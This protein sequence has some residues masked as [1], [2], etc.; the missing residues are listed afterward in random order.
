MSTLLVA[1]CEVFLGSR[2]SVMEGINWCQGTGS[3]Q[4]A[5]EL[6][7]KLMSPWNPVKQC[8]QL[9]ASPAAMAPT[10]DQAVEGG[11]CWA[12]S[13]RA[14]GSPSATRPAGA[15]ALVATGLK[16]AVFPSHPWQILHG[17]QARVPHGCWRWWVAS[18][19]CRR[20]APQSSTAF[21]SANLEFAVGERGTSQAQSSDSRVPRPQLTLSCP[22]FRFHA[23]GP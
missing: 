23:G 20:R 17:A 1:P 10:A 9:E 11:C 18:S 12:G 15:G 6:A 16:G 7:K 4:G 14:H 13:E 5:N 8:C 21:A 2:T 22:T 19:S 3:S